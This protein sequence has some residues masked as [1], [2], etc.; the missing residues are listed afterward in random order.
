M[1]RR[2][3]MDEFPGLLHRDFGLRPQ[4][5]GAPMSATKTG[6]GSTARFG[7]GAGGSALPSD[8]FGGDLQSGHRAQRDDDDFFGV[9]GGAPAKYSS[10]SATFGSDP[11]FSMG[12]KLGSSPPVEVGSSSSMPVFD[13]P[14][15]DDEGDIF[16]GVPGMK[17]VFPASSTVQNDVFA[18]P[19]YEDDLL[20]GLGGSGPGSRGS[21]V[22]GGARNVSGKGS[23]LYDDSLLSGFGDSG[24]RKVSNASSNRVS[25]PFDD[26]LLASLGG[27]KAYTDSRR[28]GATSNHS[29]PSYEADLLA[30]L[31][32]VPRHAGEEK[33]SQAKE[34]ISSFDDLIP[35]FGG[36]GL[37]GQKR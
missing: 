11:F 37:S 36:S 10:A 19:A 32:G 7:S 23:S 12:T 6:V 1:V 22:N 34:S 16:S 17:K 33:R 26:D 3:G 31:S 9:G 5:K 30:G 21:G 8:L 14:V 25:P 18:T 35:G 4:G 24:D 2:G 29:P 28:S 27:G 20:A 15:Y 13:K